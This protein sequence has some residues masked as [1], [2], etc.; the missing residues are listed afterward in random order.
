[1]L[2]EI[3]T[4]V[5]GLEKKNRVA[6]IVHGAA[7]QVPKGAGCLP[8]II[9]GGLLAVPLTCTLPSWVTLLVDAQDPLI[10]TIL[11]F[12]AVLGVAGYL[13]FRRATY[14]RFLTE[15]IIQPAE[16]S[17]VSFDLVLEELGRVKNL[18]AAVKP[19]L[20]NRNLLIQLLRERGK[21]PAYVQPDARTLRFLGNLAVPGVVAG[22][23][24]L[25]A[26]SLLGAWRQKE[27]EKVQSAQQAAQFAV[28][29]APFQEHI[30]EYLRADLPKQ[31][32]KPYL[33]GRIIPVDVG[34]KRIDGIYAA[35]PVELRADRPEDV[36]TIVWLQWGKIKVG[37]YQQNKVEALVLTCKVT[38]ID[39]QSGLI[40]G[41]NEFRG[42]NPPERWHA[43]VP[44]YGSKPTA[45]VIDWLKSLPRKPES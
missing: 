25:L 27:I 42:S 45:P 33:S 39:K 29:M 13:A 10:L 7:L 12:V 14:R 31:V 21:C 16:A 8:M 6:R 35:L 1:L 34:D 4:Y 37:E 24:V 20:A 40:V 41:E 17:K 15:Y 3:A 44:N 30:A 38:V 11:G 18:T 19:I 28:Q 2:D 43:G 36:A 32:D 5:D 26:F 22:V 9:V 23:W